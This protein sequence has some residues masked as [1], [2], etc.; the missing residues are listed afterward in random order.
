VGNTLYEVFMPDTHLVVSGDPPAVIAKGG[1]SGLFPD[2]S[3]NAYVFAASTQDSALWC[4]VRLTKDAVGICLPDIR[5]DNCTSIAN[6]FPKG[7]NTYRVNGVSTK[8]WFSVDYD[9]SQLA[10]V[11]CKCKCS[12]LF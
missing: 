9:S 12:L 3:E 8:G 4:D 7:G 1:F 11:F 10:N 5:M 2:S 6:V